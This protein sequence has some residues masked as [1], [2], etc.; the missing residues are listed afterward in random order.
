MI[1]NICIDYGPL[2]YTNL[3]YNDVQQIILPSAWLTTGLGLIPIGIFLVDRFPRP[4]FMAFGVAGCMVTLI[5]EAALIANFVPSTNTTALKAAVA[6][7]FVFQP[8]YCIFTN[9]GS[10]PFWYYLVTK[11]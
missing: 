2:L 1:V 8:F 3:G 5:I 11:G 4:Q 6:M 7:L 9:G 10:S